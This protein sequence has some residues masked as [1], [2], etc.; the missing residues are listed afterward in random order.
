M[1]TA[2]SVRGKC[3]VLQVGSVQ[4]RICPPLR[5][6]SGCRTPRKSDG[7]HANRASRGRAPAAPPRAGRAARPIG[8]DRPGTAAASMPLAALAGDRSMSSGASIGDRS[9]AKCARSSTTPRNTISP[10]ARR[11]SAGAISPINSPT[12]TS[13]APPRAVRRRR[14]R[15]RDSGCATPG[16]QARRVGDALT[17]QSL[18]RRRRPARS[19]LAMVVIVRSHWRQWHAARAAASRAPASQR[20]EAALQI[21]A[22]DRRWRSAPGRCR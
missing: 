10:R 14:A 16:Q 2:G 22:L 13:P 3:I 12:A 19:K 8:A 17:I 15:R 20:G 7:A 9:S 11:S 4:R 18:S 5:C 1:I 21:G 6:G